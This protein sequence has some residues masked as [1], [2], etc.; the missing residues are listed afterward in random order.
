MSTGV[1]KTH[2]AEALVENA[3]LRGTNLT[4]PTGLTVGLFTTAATESYTAGTPTGVEVSGGAYARQS[5]AFGAVAAQTSGTL[6]SNS[7]TI[8]FPVATA[9]WGVA[10]AIGIFDGSGNL[11]YYG[12]LTANLT[13]ATG[14]QVVFAIGAITILED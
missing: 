1:S 12:T 3:L 14:N 13:V 2:Y 7:G 11:I 10:V 4:A 6:D 8:T 5:I 9:S